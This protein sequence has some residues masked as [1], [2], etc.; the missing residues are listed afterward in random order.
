MAVTYY[1][2]R[3]DFDELDQQQLLQMSKLRRINGKLWKDVQY[4]KS[5]KNQ[6]FHKFALAETRNSKILGWGLLV[7]ERLLDGSCIMLYVHR[8]YRRM[9]IGTQ[10]VKELEKI[11]HCNKNYKNLGELHVF[12]VKDQGTFYDTLGY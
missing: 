10:I 12:R 2:R 8:D 4:I 1:L 11:Y 7:K 6:N 9:G 5:G 3:Y